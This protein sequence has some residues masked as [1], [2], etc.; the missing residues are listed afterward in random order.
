[1]S[2]MIH[3]IEEWLMEYGIWGLF[4]VSFADSSFFPIPP[5]VLLI[6]MGISNPDSVLWYAFLT[7]VASVLGAILGWFIGKKLGRP[8][9]R[10]II[11]EEKIQKVE[12]YFSKYGAMAILISAFTPIPYKVFTIFA[13]ISKI[14]LRVLVIWSII[15]RGARFF[16]EALFIMAL[17]ENARPFIE[18]NFT[19]ITIIASLVIVIGYI[20][21]VFVRKK[22]KN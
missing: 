7:T 3:A 17:G 13:G 18:E 1:M 6:P 10:L 8:V 14:R 11:S 22:K 12:Q 16:L 9:L 2:E 19:L 20:I 15:G 5:D 21:Y 4:F